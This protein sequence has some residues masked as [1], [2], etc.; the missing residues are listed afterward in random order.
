[1]IAPSVSAVITAYNSDA[2]IAEAVRS[3]L[4]QTFRDLEIIVV[5]DGS[6]DATRSTVERFGPAVRYVHQPNGGS[7]QARNHGLQLARGKY[8]AFL[9]GDD[10]SLPRR[11]ELQV[12]ALEEHPKVGL[13]YGNIFLMD[14]SGGNLRLR[15]GTGRYLSGSLT[16][17]LAVKNMVV[18]STITARRDLL[19]GIGGFDE[20]IRSSEDWDMLVRLSRQCEFLYIDEPLVN[21]RI[22]PHSKTANI[23][24]K[25]RAYKRVQAKIFAENDLGSDTS[26]LRRL[27]DATLMFGLAGI[28]LRYNHYVKALRYALR[29]LMTAPLAPFHLRHEIW[30][31]VSTPLIRGH[32]R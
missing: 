26:R 24:E 6:T 7:A 31:R 27:S 28:S 30:S 21:Y 9:D 14:A 11:L 32:Q 22:L 25:E 5:D 1:M 20:T 4:D 2:T 17:A 12:A 8:V 3:F 29:G 13:I 15:R 10:V 18:F 19:R 16:R 23:E